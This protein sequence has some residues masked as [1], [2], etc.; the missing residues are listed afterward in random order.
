MAVEK[1]IEDPVVLSGDIRA[2]DPRHD[3]PFMKVCFAQRA[4][5]MV[6]FLQDG[7]QTGQAER[8]RATECIRAVM[9]QVYSSLSGLCHVIFQKLFHEFKELQI[10]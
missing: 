3:L 7:S 1:K 9:L 6:G 10:K 2:A 8:D 4:E 5:Y